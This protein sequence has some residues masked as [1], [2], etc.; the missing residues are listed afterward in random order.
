MVSSIVAGKRSRSSEVTGR[1]DLIVVP[2]SPVAT[3]F[4]Y[5][6]YWM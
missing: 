1:R 6:Q 5:S 4:R 2:R 3:V